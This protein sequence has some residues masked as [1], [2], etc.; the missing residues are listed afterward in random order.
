MTRGRAVRGDDD[1]CRATS[2]HP[3][4]S[5]TSRRERR[6]WRR[7]QCC[8]SLAVVYNLANYWW[9]K[10]DKR[11]SER[12]KESQTDTHAQRLWGAAL[13]TCT[14]AYMHCAL[15]DQRG[16]LLTL[17]AVLS[18]TMTP[19]PPT[20]VSMH[21]CLCTVMWCGDAVVLHAATAHRGA[22]C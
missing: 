1:V 6:A 5:L 22:R 7:T 16:I 21:A 3:R 15:G 13:S 2:S 14:L 20:C 10:A 12:V 18:P 19:A 9:A 8:I 11:E 17:T 4:P